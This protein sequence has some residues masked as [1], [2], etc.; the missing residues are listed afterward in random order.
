MM[1]EAGN[2]PHCFFAN[3][4]QTHASCVII[5]IPGPHTVLYPINQKVRIDKIEHN[6]PSQCCR[7][8]YLIRRLYI[9]LKKRQPPKEGCLFATGRIGLRRYLFLLLLVFLFPQFQSS[10]KLIDSR[11]SFI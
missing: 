10:M 7:N 1:T 8:I 3:T 9:E 2:K 6:N 5:P 4:N 11:K